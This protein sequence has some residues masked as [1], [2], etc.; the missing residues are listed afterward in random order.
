MLGLIQN[1]ISDI[2]PLVDNS[3]LGEGDDVIL[4]NKTLSERSVNV[5]IPELEARGVTVDY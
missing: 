5:H 4:N 2:S 3:G 1:E